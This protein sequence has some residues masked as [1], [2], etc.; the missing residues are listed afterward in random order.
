MVGRSPKAAL[1]F[2]TSSARSFSRQPSPV[3]GS[4][5]RVWPL[6]G[7][8]VG[9]QSA[10]YGTASCR[11]REGL[12]SFPQPWRYSPR[13]TTS[14][15]LP[16]TGSGSRGALAAEGGGCPALPPFKL[17][18]RFFLRLERA[19]GPGTFC[20]TAFR[21]REHPPSSFWTEGLVRHRRSPA[22]ALGSSL[23]LSAAGGMR[24]GRLRPPPR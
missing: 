15:D 10:P 20:P 21:S 22:A 7:S 6:M 23:V 8:A 13:P 2:L 11:R 9:F 16:G 1:T 14:L 5:G 18:L 19:A 12:Q 3:P 4:R 17:W 24:P